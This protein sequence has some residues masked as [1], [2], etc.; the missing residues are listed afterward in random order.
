MLDIDLYCDFVKQHP[1][2]GKPVVRD[3][4]CWNIVL[5]KILTNH[6][7][8]RDIMSLAETCK[9]F[10]SICSSDIIWRFIYE[11][12]FKLHDTLVRETQFYKACQEIYGCHS[13]NLQLQLLVKYGYPLNRFGSVMNL[14]TGAIPKEPKE[15]EYQT[16]DS[17]ETCLCN[18]CH[19]P[20]HLKPNDSMTNLYK[21]YYCSSGDA[22]DG[23]SDSENT[24]QATSSVDTKKLKTSI[25]QIKITDMRMSNDKHE[26]DSYQLS[27]KT[28]LKRRLALLIKHAMKYPIDCDDGLPGDSS[29]KYA[30][31]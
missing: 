18:S 15:K 30:L 12:C 29:T 8:I 20:V 9:F 1:C 10:Y 31:K 25:S 26:D 23:N 24:T 2:L 6:L 11:K 3:F 7:S 27:S 17:S 5:K 21:R 4:F 22:I 13:Q 16:D 19:S 28:E 14:N